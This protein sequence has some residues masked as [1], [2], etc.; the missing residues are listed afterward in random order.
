MSTAFTGVPVNLIAPPRALAAVVEPAYRAGSAHCL[1]AD[2]RQRRHR[3]P[4]KR[5]TRVYCQSI[6]K[7]PDFGL[8]SYTGCCTVQSA[9]A[10]CCLQTVSFSDEHNLQDFSDEHHLQDYSKEER[11]DLAQKSRAQLPSFG[12]TERQAVTNAAHQRMLEREAVSPHQSAMHL[13]CYEACLLRTALPCCSRQCHPASSRGRAF[14]AVLQAS[15]AA[16]A[17][18]PD[19]RSAGVPGE[20]AAVQ[21][22]AAAPAARAVGV[23]DAAVP[24]DQQ[25]AGAQLQPG[26]ASAPQ[27]GAALRQRPAAANAMASGSACAQ[28]AAPASFAAVPATSAP[29]SAVDAAGQA[30]QAAAPAMQAPAPSWEETGL[31]VLAIGIVAAI[32]A[33]LIRKVIIGFGSYAAASHSSF[34]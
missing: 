9:A 10:V 2:A 27:P 24:Y 8:S 14:V 34:M 11:R 5:F 12:N 17:A 20:P 29:Y 22:P 3:L 31:T 4:G 15:A 23:S 21:S 13:L 7:S 18:Q 26:S 16:Q 6:C 32:A 28:P 30:A 33:L 19:G 1:H 25:P